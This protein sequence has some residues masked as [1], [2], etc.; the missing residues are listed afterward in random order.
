MTIILYTLAS[1][2]AV[3]LVSVVGA[4]TLLV[5]EKILNRYT[6]VLVS[7][8]VG[9]LL[10][11][12]FIHLLPEA[13]SDGETPSTV[14]L[15]VIGGIIGF[16]VLEKVL[17]WHHHD[18][19]CGNIHPSGKMI[20]FSDAVHNFIDGA[21]IAAGYSLGTEVGLA[22]TAAVLLHEVPQ[23][24]GDFG[25]LINAGYSKL[26]A[27]WLNFASALTAF[28][29]AGTVLLFGQSGHELAAAL[30]PVAAGGFVYVALSDLIPELKEKPGGLFWQILIILS[31]VTAVWLI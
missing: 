19:C 14:S 23:E 30:V 18:T 2:L 27:L 3:S 1:V 5:K 4:V 29:G 25:V 15:S 12:A 17:H 24:I 7:L 31:G 10:G 13:F 8:A 21:I 16:F 28:M 26:R 20:L 6:F 22:T 11:N 9:A